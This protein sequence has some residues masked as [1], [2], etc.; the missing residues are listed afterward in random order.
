MVQSWGNGW[1]FCNSFALEKEGA[2][3]HKYIFFFFKKWACL[4]LTTSFY[5]FGFPVIKVI[6]HQGQED[7]RGILK[8]EKRGTWTK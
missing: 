2:V 4:L 7:D 5:G 6:N 1:R 3:I 8:R